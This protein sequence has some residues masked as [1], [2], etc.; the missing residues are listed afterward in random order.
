[1]H[2]T[3]IGALTIPFV[4]LGWHKAGG[5]W[6]RS[7]LTLGRSMSSWAWEL[8]KTAVVKGGFKKAGLY[9]YKQLAVMRYGYDVNSLLKNTM[10]AIASI[11]VPWSSIMDS[12]TS[13]FDDRLPITGE[14]VLKAGKE[15]VK[16]AVN[17]LT[18]VL[19]GSGGYIKTGV[20][21]MFITL[22]VLVALTVYKRT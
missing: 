19:P 16:E 15:K 13:T 20:G 11:D 8:D 2:F 1:M 5:K 9:R 18:N 12:M 17:A 14:E 10:L 3:P 7:W 22:G 4:N 21:A 6:N